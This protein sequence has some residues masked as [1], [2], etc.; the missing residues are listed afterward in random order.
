M[1]L[2]RE[3]IKESPAYTDE[4]MLTRDY[5]IALHGHYSRQDYW[6]D[7]LANSDFGN[8]CCSIWRWP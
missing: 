7:E 5:E 2:S 4:A 8:G 1:N 3:T 6:I